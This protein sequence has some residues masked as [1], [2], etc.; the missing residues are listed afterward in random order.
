MKV[1]K[2]ISLIINYKTFIIT[3]LALVS[4]WLCNRYN[5]VADF[6]LTIIGIA[7][8]FPVVFSIDSAYKRR[9]FVLGQLG[10]FKNH[11]RAIYHASRDWLEPAQPQ[12]QLK[13]KEELMNVYN[14]LITCFTTEEQHL[15]VNEEKLQERLSDLSKMLQE[16]RKYDLEI[17]EMP[18]ISQYISKV[19]LALEN[20]KIVLKYRTPVT[21]RAYS[22]IFIYSFPVLYGPYF[23]YAARQYSPGLEYFMPVIFTFI[24]VS[25]D[26]IQNHL[27]NPFDQIG[28]DDIK[29]DLQSFS[30]TLR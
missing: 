8:V 24:L 12:F 27:E 18:R 21:L 6:P 13:V 7:I 23:V 30:D 2:S 5:I 9:E 19:G 20:M 4:T 22:K 26:N 28:E 1:L 3:F 16:F 14:T 10:D 25:L 15:H 29:F 17:G 11:L